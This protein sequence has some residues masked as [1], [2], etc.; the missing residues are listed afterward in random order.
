MLDDYEF[1]LCLTHDVDRV[2]KSFQC[3]H[4]AMRER[5]LSYPKSLI[6]SKNPLWPFEEIM[7]IED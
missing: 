1:A 7:E 5:G 2:H 3:P 6:S 4:Y